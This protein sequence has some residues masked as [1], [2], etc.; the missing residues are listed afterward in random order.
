M[1]ST[2]IWSAR[3]RTIISLMSASSA[4]FMNCP[5]DLVRLSM[6]NG[7]VEK[8]IGGWQIHGHSYVPLRESGRYHDWRSELAYGQRHPARLV[9]L[10]NGHR[11][12][13]RCRHQLPRHSGRYG[14]SQSRSFRQS[15]GVCRRSECRTASRQRRAL[16]A[17]RS[18]MRL[19][20]QRTSACTSSLRL[21]EVRSV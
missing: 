1:S 7:F 9:V 19:S 11:S 6:V 18:A 10:G 3:S 16:S 21:D 4:G 14:V 15:S 13:Q 20:S 17:E 12:Q 5:S 2:A 8:I